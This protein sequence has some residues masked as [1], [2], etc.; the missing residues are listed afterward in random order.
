MRKVISF[1]VHAILV[2]LALVGGS[3]VIDLFKF[4]RRYFTEHRDEYDFHDIT[5]RNKYVEDGLEAYFQD[6]AEWASTMLS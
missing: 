6:R 5:D 4:A 3:Y 1:I 2:L